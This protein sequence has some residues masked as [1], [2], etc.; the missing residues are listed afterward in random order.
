MTINMLLEWPI[1]RFP[2][3]AA[4]IFKERSLTF[5][6]VDAEVNRL[7]HGLLEMGFRIGKKIAIL[8]PNGFEICQS[9][10]ALTRLGVTTVALN[11]RHSAEEHI[12]ILNDSET[13][14]IILDAMFLDSFK[15]VLPQTPSVKT[16]IVSG[17]NTGGFTRLSD[18][19]SG[20]PTTDPGI[21]TNPDDIDRIQY[22]SGT[23]GKPKGAVSTNGI[24]YNRTMH[25]LANL[26]QPINYTD[27]N[28]SV[29]PLTHAA[30]HYFTFTFIRGATNVI[31]D[32]FDPV[33]TLKAI[34]KYSISCLFLV[35]TA[36]IKMLEV[37]DVNKYDLSSLKYV[38]YGASP[39]PSTRLKEAI[40][41][42]GPVF[43]QNYGMTECTQPIT[44]LDVKDHVAN[45]SPLQMKRLA[46][47][48]RTALNVQLKIVDADGNPLPRGE[49]GE[50]VIR[51]NT[52]MKEYYKKPAPTAE[53]LRSGWYHSS[54]M[55]YLDEDG[56]LFIV[57]RKN[58]TIVS[59]GF[60]IYPREVEDAINS[61]PGV[62]DSA[63]VGVPDNVW[64]ES[65]KAFVVKNAGTELSADDIIQHVKNTL[66]SYKKPKIVE[67]I[68]QIPRDANG[69]IL[70]RRLKPYY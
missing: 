67:F 36:I 42:F 64:V 28:L 32:K 35:P 17:Q 2:D 55:G 57:D 44:Y 63:V 37:S 29:T 34:E 23:T 53:T 13:D 59:G 62:Q 6:E 58:D 1:N 24:T 14:G 12:Y 56:Y 45:G 26:D 69:K 46:S 70:R 54:D 66:A 30:M 8:M 16:V 7:A 51:S 65:V 15:D 4:I 47:A 11:M 19:A 33:E 3:K 60:N 38:W 40:E 21:E 31:L 9:F 18:L 39:F 52:T 22:T 43:R 48:G 50:I 10:I 61:I 20:R 49:M 68:D 25:V 27:A 41:V 5:K